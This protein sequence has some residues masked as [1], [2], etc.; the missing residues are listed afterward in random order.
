MFAEPRGSA[1]LSRPSVV[2]DLGGTHLRAALVSEDGAILKRLQELTPQEEAEPVT[3][4]RL[5]AAVASDET[6]RAAIGVPG[7][8]D[9]DDETLLAAPNLPQSWIKYLNEEWLSERSGLAVSMANDADL[10][11]VGEATF[12]AGRGCRDVVYVTIST[13]IGAGIVLDGRLMRGRYSGGEV[14]HSVIDRSRSLLGDD[15]T[16]EGLGSGTAIRNAAAAAGLKAQGAGLA[17]MVRDHDPGASEVW[18]AAIDA[19]AFGVVNLCWIVTPQLVVIGGGVGMNSDIVL[20]T[21]HQRIRDHGP[22]VVPIGVVSAS[23]GD[24]AA[25][26]GGAAWWQAI[27]RS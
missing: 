12:G 1:N 16:V 14:G 13:G 21:I 8:V 10:A 26:I 7:V 15:G 24:D 2:I 19:A 18:N 27:G 3:L 4:L 20:P 22:S 9:Y 11:A 23:L 5:M 6:D 25:L 17:D